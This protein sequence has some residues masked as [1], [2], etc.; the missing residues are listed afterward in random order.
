M[1]ISVVFQQV[2]YKITLKHS[3]CD[4]VLIHQNTWLFNVTTLHSYSYSI[5]LSPLIFVFLNLL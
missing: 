4:S 2:K 1:E 3:R 5:Y